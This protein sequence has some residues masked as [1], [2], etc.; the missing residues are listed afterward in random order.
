MKDITRD[1]VAKPLANEEATIGAGVRVKSILWRLNARDVALIVV[2][3]G[4]SIYFTVQSPY[5]FNMD[6]LL[7]I[8]R[9]AVVTGIVAAGETVVLISGG[10]DL[11]ISSVMAAAGMITAALIHAGMPTYPAILVGL[12]FGAMVGFINGI[13]ITKMRI[14]PLITTLATMSIVRGACYVMSNGLSIA[15]GDETFRSMGL[16]KVF[17]IP[18]PA[19][20]L[21]IVYAIIYVLLRYTQFGRYAYAIGGNANSCRLCG[22]N[23]DRW[24]LITYILCGI[25]SAFGGIVLTALAGTGLPNAALGYELIVISAVILGG[26]GL[27]GGEGSVMGTLLAMVVIST[28]TNGMTLMSFPVY[29]HQII[30]GFLLLLAVLI[31]A[32][33]TGGYK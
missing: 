25:C 9:S 33:R 12:S 24:R 29:W 21:I 4:L 6:N 30:R 5:F 8:A 18:K 19:I 13:I 16:G 26:T 7:N 2:L 20:M 15:I 10:I 11:S 32:V 23:V 28:L 31:D 17:E 1:Q 14:N 3:V 27:A 22:L